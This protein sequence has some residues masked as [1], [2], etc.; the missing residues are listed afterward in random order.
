M[1]PVIQSCVRAGLDL[2]PVG[3]SHSLGSLGRTASCGKDP[4]L[5]QG[6]GEEEGAA[7]MG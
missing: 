7:E 4:V 3:S 6:H 5:G 2:Q 1:G